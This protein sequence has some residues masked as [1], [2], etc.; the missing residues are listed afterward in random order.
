VKK[1][2]NVS[3]KKK[4]LQNR[5]SAQKSIEKKKNIIGQIKSEKEL[6]SSENDNLRW[7]LDMKN[8]EIEQLR[9]TI[10]LISSQ[11]PKE[12]KQLYNF[13]FTVGRSSSIFKIVACVI[14]V[15]CVLQCC[16]NPSTNLDS[17]RPAFVEPIISPIQRVSRRGKDI[18]E[19]F[20]K[21]R[22][23]KYYPTHILNRTSDATC[24]NRIDYLTSSCEIEANQ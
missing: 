10:N 13:S 2:E 12:E 18:N 4:A 8:R 7:E 5:I 20:N 22:Q 21:G 24:I 15:M 9:S 19:I 3:K 16:Y 6:L 14:L 23:C 1:K 17:N 11:G